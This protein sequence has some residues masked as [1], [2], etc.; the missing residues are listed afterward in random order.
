MRLP[1]GPELI[2]ARARETLL[3]RASSEARL[4][5]REV[6]AA[7]RADV[8]AVAGRAVRER[9]VVPWH[10]RARVALVPAERAP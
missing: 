5:V 9:L 8:P 10:V 7:A 3:E 6:R 4:R 1:G 2:G